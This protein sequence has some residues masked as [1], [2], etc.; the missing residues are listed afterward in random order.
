MIGNSADVKC[1]MMK[2]IGI[3]TNDGF[4][5]TDDLKNERDYYNSL[6]QLASMLINGE[7]PEQTFQKKWV[8]V[9]SEP[10]SIQQYV[11]QPSINKRYEL[12]D[13]LLKDKFKEVW[14]L[15]ETT[16]K[17]ECEQVRAEGFIPDL[18]EYKQD[19]QP[20]ILQDVEFEY[21][22]IV[23]IDEI[24]TPEIFSYKR[25][26]EYDNSKDYGNVTEKDIKYDMISQIISPAILLHTQ[27]C[28]LGAKESYDLVRK[29]IKQNINY[30]VAE[31]TSDYDFCFTVKKKIA[32][33]Q[34]HVY[35]VD[36]NNTFFGKKRKPKYQTRVSKHDSISIFEMTPANKP[37]ERYTPLP[38]F[39][40]DSQDSLKENIDSYLR[41]LIGVIN[42]PLQYC[43][44]CNG[45]GVKFRELTK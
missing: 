45:T 12:I 23:E 7:K 9:K 17:V 13:K 40:G 36:V 26:G 37:Y 31:I 2:I 19:D 32:L 8:K 33:S 44:C 3:K 1:D 27:P 39:E 11:S 5:I 14:L 29:Y 42:E 28:K 30:D 10:K 41:H 4:Y 35:Q 16:V 21:Q 43:E 24:K 6:T 34:P 20:N 25:S 22:T 18:Y 38:P 15:E